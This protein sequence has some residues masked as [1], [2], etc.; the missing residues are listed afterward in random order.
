M[1]SSLY[2]Q[3][4]YG[5]C[6]V[7]WQVSSA[8]ESRIHAQPPHRYVDKEAVTCK[9][10]VCIVSVLTKFLNGTYK[11]SSSKVIRGTEIYC[12]QVH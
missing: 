7:V 10:S 5:V 3:D 4:K 9:T 11:I 12:G 8:P 1:A 2:E 6:L